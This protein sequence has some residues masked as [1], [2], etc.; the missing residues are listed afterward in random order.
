M[1]RFGDG[2]R[3]LAP[4]RPALCDESRGEQAT[5]GRLTSSSS[6]SE[7]SDT[8]CGERDGSSSRNDDAMLR[9]VASCWA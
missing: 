6:G 2:A 8:I 4:T 9:I 7:A 5:S 3:S 1:S